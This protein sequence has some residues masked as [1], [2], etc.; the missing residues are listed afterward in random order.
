MEVIVRNS[1]RSLIATALML[2]ALLFLA[3][4]PASAQDIS[5]FVDG[6]RLD[7]TPVS[8]GGSTL[9]PL[10]GIF[11]ALGAEVKWDGPTRTV[12][13]TR[14]A[15]QIELTLD[16]PLALVD[17]EI[18]RLDVPARS[19]GGRTMV[20]LRFI[21]EALGA[22]V[23]WQGAT[24]TVLITSPEKAGGE[25]SLAP[26]IT[27]VVL[28]PQ[29]TLR[30]GDTLTV[31]MTG[32]PQG[33]AT[34]DILGVRTGIP[35]AEET[36]GRYS[37]TLT[38]PAGLASDAATLLV[39]LT[40]SGQ[41]TV[42]EAPGTVT[43]QAASSPTPTPTASPTRTITEFPAPNA[44]VADRRPVVGV[45]FNQALTAGQVRIFVDGRDFTNEARISG[46]R[47]SWQPTYDLNF[48][49]HSVRVTGVDSLGNRLERRWNFT[50]GEQ[51][52]TTRFPGIN[53]A[54][55]SPR[56]TIGI[57]FPQAI[58]ADSARLWVDGQEFTHQATL[59]PY[60]ISWIPPYDLSSGTHNVRVDA[61]TTMGQPLN[62]VWSFS[63]S[64]TQSTTTS[65]GL[66]H[67]LA[68]TPNPPYSIGQN[69]TVTLYGSQGGTTTFDVGG[70][71]GF[72]MRETS[73]GAYQGTYTVSNQDTSTRLSATLRLPDGR[74]QT[75]QSAE[76]VTV[77]PS[78]GNP[79]QLSVTSPSDRQNVDG[80]FNVIGRST[81][82]STVEVTAQVRQSLIPGVISIAGRT[83]SGSAVADANGHFNVAIGATE[84]AVGSTL[85]ISV[86]ARDT[87][88]N[89][90]APVQFQVIRQ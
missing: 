89:T 85:D 77:N 51:G 52:Q 3:S 82:N 8:V 83:F 57:S 25:A 75:I 42:Q 31:I 41:E 78:P 69:V 56:P 47:I 80:N 35:M 74:S 86:R 45:H 38:I 84:A 33:Q 88:G 26:R 22:K 12:R 64:G 54:V 20:P 63:I 87:F 67:S 1:F 48:G 7:Q 14:E 59:T 13:A 37:G 53:T 34:F 81:P 29:R 27:K 2:G 66:I 68:M 79:L 16:S 32:D 6:K 70:R 60:E 61:A 50:L 76:V 49:S 40:R 30:A 55:Q 90:T 18:K 62:E 15:T 21:G 24:R 23:E 39:H 72:P 11:E 43:I 46:T 4:Q 19:I 9:V 5:V 73:P 65:T 44:V 71:T 10:R 17:G 36:P 58:Q 28:S